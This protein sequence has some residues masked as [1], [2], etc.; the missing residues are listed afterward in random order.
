[1]DLVFKWML[2]VLLCPIGSG[3]KGGVIY[4]EDVFDY[5]LLIFR[6]RNFDFDWS[7]VLSSFFKNRLFIKLWFLVTHSISVKLVF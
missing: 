5:G 7:D 6:L 2:H 1:M 4:T 3:K